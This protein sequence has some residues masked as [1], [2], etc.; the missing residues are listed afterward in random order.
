MAAR[1][2]SSAVTAGS[3]TS[4]AAHVGRRRVRQSAPR[5]SRSRLLCSNS[6]QTR[7]DKQTELLSLVGDGS[8]ESGK[9]RTETNKRVEEL[10][11]LLQQENPTPN[12]SQSE[13]LPG[14][15]RLLS[16]FKPGTASVS[17]FSL[18]DWQNYFFNDGPSPVQNLVVGN[19]KTVSRVYQVLDLTEK[20]RF[21][22]VVDFSEASGGVLVIEAK[23]TG[24]DGPS[25]IK[26]R[27]SG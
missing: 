9:S 8:L 18:Q 15:W 27:F 23:I 7:L 5:I 24:L 6:S 26:F 13:F 25:N 21:L 14:R 10:V 20:K 4:L 22:N 12:P 11:K 17:F 1:V 2:C 3:H 19:T 16:S